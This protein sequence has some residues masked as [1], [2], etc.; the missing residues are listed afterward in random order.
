M[1]SY[2]GTQSGRRMAGVRAELGKRCGRRRTRDANEKEPGWDP[3]TP[4]KAGGLNLETALEVTGT[5][6]FQKQKL[7]N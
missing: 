7:E 4:T 6:L 1:K 5:H 3:T 2:R